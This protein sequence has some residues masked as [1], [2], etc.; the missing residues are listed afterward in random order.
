MTLSYDPHYNIAY[1]R[2][3]EKSTNVETIRISDELF[4]DM[5]SDGTIYGIELLNA[6]EQL[7]SENGGKLSIINEA[8]GKRAELNLDV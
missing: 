7:K 4:V 8:T 6:R 1:I 2:F 3:K 5:S